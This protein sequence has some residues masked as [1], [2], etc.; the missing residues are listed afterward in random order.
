MANAPRRT[1]TIADD[2][3]PLLKRRDREKPKQRIASEKPRRINTLLVDKEEKVASS[4][5]PS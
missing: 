4:L 5:Q 2:S 3:T 1:N